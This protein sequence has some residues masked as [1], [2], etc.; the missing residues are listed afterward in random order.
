MPCEESG[1]GCARP[2]SPPPDDRTH[3]SP[4]GKRRMSDE[5][6]RDEETRQMRLELE[7][8]QEQYDSSRPK[9]LPD[10]GTE[11]EWS[12]HTEDMKRMQALR[13]RWRMRGEERKKR[14]LPRKKRDPVTGRPLP[15]L[16]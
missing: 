11:E 6:E 12:V 1:G 16:W 3:H 4:R 5:E 7:R 8:E 15:A 9:S 2:F 10:G 14:E 13:R